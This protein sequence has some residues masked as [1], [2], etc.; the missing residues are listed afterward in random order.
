MI[1]SSQNFTYLY[2]C[3]PINIMIITCKFFI[4]TP[5]DYIIIIVY[6]HMY[7]YSLANVTYVV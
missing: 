7:I 3:I 2:S 4:F 6:I 1:I 5:L